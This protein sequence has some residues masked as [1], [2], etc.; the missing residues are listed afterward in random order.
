M[1]LQASI[2]RVNDEAPPL[3]ATAGFNGDLLG[4][5]LIANPTWPADP[6]F[7]PGGAAQLNPLN[8]LENYEA[9]SNTD[10]I[11][12]NLAATYDIT[13]NLNARVAVGYDDTDTQTTT[14]YSAN[15]NGLGTIS[16]NGQ[17]TLQ[18]F[19]GINKLLEATLNYNKQFDDWSIDALVGFSYQEFKRNGL[20]ANGFG[21]AA[22]SLSSQRDDLFD[23]LNELRGVVDDNEQVYGFGTNT[24]FAQSLDDEG[25]IIQREI[26]DPFDRSVT[27][28]TV[29]EFKNS[30]ELQSFF[31]RSNLTY[32]DKFLLTATIRADGSTSFGP[33]ETYGY[34]PSGA[35]A[36]KIHEEDFVGDAVSTL[37]LRLG[38]GVVGN[39][40]GLGFANFLLRQGIGGPGITPEGEVQPGGTA[41]FGSFSPDLKWESTTDLNVGVDFGF[42][43][44]RLNGSFNVYRK[45]TND[46]LFERVTGVPGNGSRVFEN[47]SDFEVINQG[48]E[49]SVNYDFIDNQDWGFSASLNVAFNDN[50]VEGAPGSIDTGQIRGQ[51]LTGAFA[52]RLESGQPLFSFFLPIF[53]GFDDEGLPIYTDIDGDGIGDPSLDKTFV[54]EDAQPDVT[55]GLSLNA[56]YKR[57]DLGVFLNSQLGFSVY[58]ATANA[59]FTAGNPGNAR[60]TIASVVNSGESEEASADVSTR[61]L[62]DGDF[63]RLQSLSLGYDWPISGE[64]FFDSLRLSASAQN[65]FLITGYS[66]IDPEVT[67]NTGDLGSGVPSLGIDYSSFPRPTTITLGVNAKF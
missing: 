29:D 15:V 2:S 34:F 27:A 63:V 57:W 23:T 55:A 6:N 31:F 17:G 13:D 8:L 28:F 52:Q 30:D 43:N 12:V 21:S 64:G 40:Q 53:E 62:E 4:S 26:L 48:V 35:F 41:S 50:E 59:F 46:L 66:G 49:L 24:T 60:N 56:R 36:W 61:F 67:S 16:G 25:V 11:L 22:G 19:Q 18:T 37:K 58:N 20:F 45:T 42:N 10:R 44:D 14:V 38:A 54:G 65:L 9:L 51:G 33:N 47:L 39:Q 3:A 7:N 1:D 5:A 32:K